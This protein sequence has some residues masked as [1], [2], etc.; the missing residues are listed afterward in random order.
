LPDEYLFD[1]LEK[2]D[3]NIVG[4]KKIYSYDRIDLINKWIGHNYNKNN[5]IKLGVMQVRGSDFQNTKF[6][7]ITKQ[8]FLSS[9]NIITKSNLQDSLIFNSVRKCINLTWINH[10]DCFMYPSYKIKEQENVLEDEVKVFDF[11]QD[12]EFINNCIIFALFEKNYTDW[13]MFL[14]SEIGLNGSNR[15]LTIYDSLI[16]GKTFSNE[17]KDV[18]EAAKKIFAFYHTKFDN[19]NAGYCEIIKSLKESFKDETKEMIDELQRKKKT[20][21]LCIADKLVEYGFL[22]D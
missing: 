10:D 9:N 15:D 4:I 11:E 13:Q 17:A 12:K 7:S 16:K 21:K 20:L 1:I 5:E 8:G 18:R 19:E 14:D 3:G 2:K 22:K 6:I